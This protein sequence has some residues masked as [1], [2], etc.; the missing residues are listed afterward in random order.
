MVM[1][2][3]QMSNYHIIMQCEGVPRNGE[4]LQ[5]LSIDG[6]VSLPELLPVACAVREIT[7]WYAVRHKHV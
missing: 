7:S 4:I 3:L 1:V 2:A 5:I 6:S